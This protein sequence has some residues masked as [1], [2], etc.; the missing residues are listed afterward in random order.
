[1]AS[2]RASVQQLDP[3][4]RNE[5]AV[6]YPSATVASFE[7]VQPLWSGYGQILRVSLMVDS[8]AH[9]AADEGGASAPTSVVV[10]RVAP[11]KQTHPSISHARKCRSYQVEVAFYERFSTQLDPRTC[12]VPRL[13]SSRRGGECPEEVLLVLEDLDAAG[14]PGRSEELTLSDAQSVVTWLAN[15][16]RTFL[17]RRPAQIDATA[18]PTNRRG[19]GSK[20]GRAK[21]LHPGARPPARV[22]VPDEATTEQAGGMWPQGTYWHLATRPEELEQMDDRDVLKANAA[23]IDELLRSARHTTLLHGDAKLANFCMQAQSGPVAAVDFQY[24]GWGPGVV[25]LAYA[26]GSFPGLG[27]SLDEHEAG[28]L[29][30]YFAELAADDPTVEQEWREL[31]CVAV[32][33]FERFLAGWSPGHWKRN[34]YTARKAKEALSLIAQRRAASS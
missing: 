12:R 25:D 4:V 2:R 20:P 11:P 17:D 14:F 30:L 6:L 10:K 29:D 7:L 34:G 16:H 22:P 33:D 32:A 23:A 3:V 18:S 8:L 19:R 26:I 1:M 31:Y 13:L 21:R 27:A 15:F 24:A 28:L 9:G 5:L